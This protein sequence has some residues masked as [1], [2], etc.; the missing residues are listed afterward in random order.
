M[1]QEKAFTENEVKMAL[2]QLVEDG[3]LHLIV[4]E[5]GEPLYIE[6]TFRAGYQHAK[7]E[8]DGLAPIS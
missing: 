5:D 1:K 4:R 2:N 3:K 7:R 6:N 8:I